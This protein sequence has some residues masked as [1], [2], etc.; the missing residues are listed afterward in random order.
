METKQ[1]RFGELDTGTD[2]EWAGRI[3]RK[4][5]NNR[6]SCLV[7]RQ[8]FIFKNS[9]MVIVFPKPEKKD[10]EEDDILANM[11]GLGGV[12]STIPDHGNPLTS[13]DLA[14]YMHGVPFGDGDRCN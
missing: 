12:G 7:P 1:V 13:D 11:Y 3:L 2:F 8:D 9:D 10:D 5:T 4:E 6:A 14:D